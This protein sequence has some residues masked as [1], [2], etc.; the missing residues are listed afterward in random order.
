MFRKIFY[1]QK[2]YIISSCGKIYNA[3]N[4]E[5]K[6]HPD[7]DGYPKVRLWDGVKYHNHFVHRLVAEAFIPNPENKPQVNHKDGDKRNNDVN[8][9]EW[10]TQSENMRH[11][12][13]VLGHKAGHWNKGRFGQY[14]NRAKI[15]LQ[16][17]DGKIIAEFYGCM[18]AQ[19]K[20]GIHFGSISNVCLGK[21]KT[22]GGY[23]WKYKLK[24][25]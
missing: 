24:G 23:K 16:I 10:V 19:R 17:K 21:G 2:Q 12:F 5:I 13:D 6:S 11:C 3:Q 20:T 4:K 15:V 22:A 18:E 8:N 7:K 14:S 9:L 1:G 25:E